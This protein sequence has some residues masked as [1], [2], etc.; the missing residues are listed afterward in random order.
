MPCV[1]LTPTK[2]MFIGQLKA[3]KKIPSTTPGFSAHPPPPFWI[4]R[5]LHLIY[6]LIFFSP[7]KITW[8]AKSWN[9]RL[10]TNWAVLLTPPVFSLCQT[11]CL[12]KTIYLYHFQAGQTGSGWEV[13]RG[14][15]VRERWLFHLLSEGIDQP[16]CLLVSEVRPCPPGAL[17]GWAV[18]V[19]SCIESWPKWRLIEGNGYW[20]PNHSET[21]SVTLKPVHSVNVRSRGTHLAPSADH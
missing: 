4:S 18:S 14:G 19:K 16:C 12:D 1:S 8:E 7:I 11:L 21:P 3:E 10:S 9:L 20:R 15:G 5:A 17:R 6:R 2:L 13:P